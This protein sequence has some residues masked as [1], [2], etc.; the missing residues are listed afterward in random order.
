MKLNGGN[1]HVSAGTGVR[2]GD[3][4]NPLIPIIRMRVSDD[5]GASI[6]LHLT[7]EKARRIGLDLLSSAVMA[8]ADTG[9]RGYA[10]DHGLDGDGMVGSVLALV[11]VA[12]ANEERVEGDQT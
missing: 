12:L 4:K 10:R 9:I 6:E 7:P 8:W 1:V 3:P 11:E 5:D 2:H